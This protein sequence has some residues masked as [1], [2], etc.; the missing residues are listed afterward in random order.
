MRG[1]DYRASLR[2]RRVVH[3]NGRRVDDLTADPTYAPAV[4]R[5][6]QTYDET[7][8]SG[9]DATNSLLVAPRS[10]E[11]LQ[12]QLPLIGSVDVL[13]L[14]T[15]QTLMTLVVAAQ[16]LPESAAHN[17]DRILDFVDDAQRRDVRAALCITDAKGHRRLPPSRQPDPDAYLRVVHRTSTGIVI[18]GAKL[19]VSGASLAHELLVM[20][21]KTM[22]PG[23]EDWSVAC[24]VPVATPGVTVIDRAY[25]DPSR[26]R[27]DQPVSHRESVP[28]GFVVFDDV[29]VPHDRVFLDGLTAQAAVFAHSLGLWARLIS[30]AN[31]VRQAD[32]LV[33]LAEL[34]AEANGIQDIPHVR[35]KI[36]EMLIHATLLRAG[37]VAA[38]AE[39]QPTRDGYY[40]PNDLYANATKYL[41]AS[42]LSVMFRN[43][44]DIAGGLAIT[45]PS[46]A[47]LA[48][49]ATGGYLAKYLQAAEGASASERMALFHAIR[50]A[51]AD[52]YGGWQ[53][54]E[55]LQGAGGLYAQRVVTRHHYDMDRAKADARESAGLPPG[56]QDG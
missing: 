26:P 6:E 5:I 8:R 10:R 35:E 18:R 32:L 1:R 42:R 4:E 43:L 46:T 54:V 23:E 49:A 30:L 55:S 51:T 31:M 50:D 45:V 52:V 28:S 27:E 22:K 38:V 7:F 41:G 25:F 33:G 16:R 56:P 14:L 11:D 2:D 39:A 13:L 12:A 3:L 17:A 40:V 53:M 21:T 47:D 19:H 48:S 34:I 24:A 9:P 15:Y 29:E 20:P 36:D 37:Q 44:H